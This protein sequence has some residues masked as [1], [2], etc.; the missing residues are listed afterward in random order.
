MIMRLSRAAAT[1]RPAPSREREQ[2]GSL[3]LSR[4]RVS[5][6]EKALY[7]RSEIDQAKGALMAI[8]H[9]ST[10]EAFRLLAQRLKTATSG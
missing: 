2:V 3:N 5:I 4:H 10:D 7:S 1:T 8:H 9:C 6:L